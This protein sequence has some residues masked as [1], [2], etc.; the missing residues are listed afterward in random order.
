MRLPRWP[1]HAGAVHAVAFHPR[2]RWLVS[3][4][5]DR[6]LRVWD[7]GSSAERCAVTLGEPVERIAPLPATTLVAVGHGLL[8]RQGG[9]VL[10]DIATGTSSRLVDRPVTAL[11]ASPDGLRVAVAEDRGPVRIWDVERREPVVTLETRSTAIHVGALSFHPDGRTLVGACEESAMLWDAATGVAVSEV[12]KDDSV[13]AHAAFSSSGHLLATGS[14]AEE[15]SAGF[16]QLWSFPDGKEVRTL[17]PDGWDLFGIAF[18]G[19]GRRL[20][21]AS[22]AGALVW[23]VATG[24]ATGAL[25]EMGR[26]PGNASDYTVSVALDAKGERLAGAMEHGG[27][28]VVDAET[29]A[30]LDS[31]ST[32]VSALTFDTAGTRVLVGCRD[33]SAALFDGATGERVV[34][35]GR[36]DG[37]VSSVALHPTEPVAILASGR[38]AHAVDLE[39]G[40]TRRTLDVGRAIQSADVAFD[41]TLVATSADGQVTGWDLRSGE[42]LF[43]LNDPMNVQL[44][45]VAL[46]PTRR[47]A[48]AVSARTP[49]LVLVDLAARGTDKTIPLPS[50]PSSLSWHPR[51]PIVAVGHMDGTI[52]LAHAGTSTCASLSPRQSAWVMSLVFSPD[53]TWLATS[54]HDR[55]AIWNVA[56]RALVR[57]HTRTAR[58]LCCAPTGELVA[59][60]DDAWPDVVDRLV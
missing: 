59:W 20:A 14:G 46:D 35:L 12:R 8:A 60:D 41:G 19:D 10:V 48:A 34:D 7:L 11:A 23:D 5:A 1:G 3:G 15:G 50:Q 56:E 28:Y 36:R 22:Q 58:Y 24:Q 17:G 33:G 44:V 2:E 4:G 57:T 42:R 30:L 31:L 53:G 38:S 21:A 13:M 43:T 37:I 32:A 9:C 51:E 39:N 18:S 29:N 26:G 16:V 6:T 49:E 45:P 52:T 27:L 54:A 25:G 40:E 47:R 55:I